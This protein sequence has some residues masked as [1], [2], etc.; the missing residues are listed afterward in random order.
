MYAFFNLVALLLIYLFVPE[1]KERTLEDLDYVFTQSTRDLAKFRIRRVRK[2]YKDRLL[3]VGLKLVERYGREEDQ[4]ISLSESLRPNG[5][6]S[7]LSR[8]PGNV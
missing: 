5:L 2:Y 8:E 6:A 1:T 3:K 7:A 4:A